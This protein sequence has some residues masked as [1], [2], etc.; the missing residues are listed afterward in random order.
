[1]IDRKHPITVLVVDDDPA[2]LDF[3]KELLAEY[4]YQTILASSGEEAL[5]IAANHPP[6]DLL[7]TDIKMPGINGITLAKQLLALYPMIKVLFMSAFSL[8]T[9]LYSIAGHKVSFLQKPF[10]VD[11]IIAKMEAALN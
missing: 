9:T 7:L 11:T 8:P 3:L 1:M 6:I 4:E 10:P 2:I 5:E